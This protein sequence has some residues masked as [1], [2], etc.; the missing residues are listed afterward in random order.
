MKT[1]HIL[2]TV[3]MILLLLSCSKEEVLPENKSLYFPKEEL[4]KVDTT[5]HI[6]YK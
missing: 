2:L 4:T 3:V 1:I 6:K 5:I